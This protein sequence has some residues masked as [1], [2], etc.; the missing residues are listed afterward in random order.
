MVLN[1]TVK[2]NRGGQMLA[3]PTGPTSHRKQ[4][5]HSTTPTLQYFTSAGA[6]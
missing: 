5:I 1:P 4:I 3:K 2:C 6:A